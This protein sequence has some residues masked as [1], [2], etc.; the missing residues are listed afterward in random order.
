MGVKAIDI[1]K[2]TQYG[3]PFLIPDWVVVVRLKRRKLRVPQNRDTIYWLRK[4]LRWHSNRVE[5][6]IADRYM[7]AM[8]KNFGGE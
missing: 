8:K 5:T 6:Y 3:T 1:G 7:Y 2:E 4:E